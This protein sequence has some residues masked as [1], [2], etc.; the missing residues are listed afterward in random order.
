MCAS[1]IPFIPSLNDQ[2]Q[3]SILHNKKKIQIFVMDM[4]FI[5]SREVKELCISFVAPPF[6]KYIFFT[7]FDEIKVIFMTKISISSMYLKSGFFFQIIKSYSSFRMNPKSKKIYS[8]IDRFMTSE[9]GVTLILLFTTK[10]G[11][12]VAQ[13][14]QKIFQFLLHNQ[15]KDI[16]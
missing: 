12:S 8:F 10:T 4:T 9:D 3:L 1:V 11:Q 13:N 6:M 15:T 7:S 14:R 16:F 5:S 2:N